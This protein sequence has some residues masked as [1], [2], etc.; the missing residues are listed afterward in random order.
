[1]KQNKIIVIFLLCLFSLSSLAQ[2]NIFSNLRLPFSKKEVM[3]INPHVLFF[4]DVTLTNGKNIVA[5]G[6][7]LSFQTNTY[8]ILHANGYL[9]SLFVR[10]NE[11]QMHSFDTM[12]L[13]YSCSFKVSKQQMKKEFAYL[14]VENIDG[15]CTLYINGQ[16][17]REYHNAFMRYND[18]IKPFLK[19]GKNKLRLVF[20]PKDSVRMNQRSPQYLYGWD[21]HPKTLAPSIS[22]IYLSFEDN[23]PILDYKSIQTKSIKKD[24]AEVLLSLKFRKPLTKKHILSLESDDYSI[25]FILKPNESGEYCFPFT[26]ENPKLWWPNGSGE[27]YLYKSK[28]LIDDVWDSDIRYG[29]RTIELVRKK[30]TLHNPNLRNKKTIGESFYFNVNGQPV[31]CK[32]ANFITGPTT[33]T[34]DI[35]LAQE[36]NMN[37]LRVWGGANYGD[38]EFYNLCDEYGIMVWQDFPF[39][40]ELYPADSSFLANVKE[41]A[42]QNI[43]RIS[44]H[45]SLALYCGNNEIWEGWNNWGWKQMVKDTTK[46]VEDYNKLFKEL[47][48]KLVSEYAPTIDYIHSSPLEYGWGHEESR[49]IG[50]CHY[51]GVWWGDST[52]E[53]YTRKV[54]RFMS[55]F[56]FQS[57]MNFSTAQKYCSSPY[58]KNND[59]F[60]I[61][62]K[63]DRGFELIDSRVK[64]WFGD[65]IKTDEDYITYTNLTAAEGLKLAIEAFRRAKP[66]C[67]GILFWQYNELY[68]CIGWG[69]IDYSSDVKPTYYTATLSYQP[70]IFSIDKY[71]NEDSVFVYACSDVDKEVELDYT[72]K[73]LDNNDSLHYKFIETTT[74]IPAN[75]SKLIASIAYKDIKD[76][77]KKTCYLW[78]EGTYEDAYINNYAFFSYP[79]DYISL[80]KYLDVI[81]FYYF[82]DDIR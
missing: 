62:Q 6:F 68:P 26:I 16:K 38:E 20:S 69:C 31:F 58:T 5:D 71:S 55:E 48:P 73:I 24:V 49:Q 14:N 22:A 50:D 35:I 53:T 75:E 78:A 7:D 17:V 2:N 72:I 56:G 44:G 80:Q 40:C 66:Y 52:F 15:N 8:E 76:F 42:T 33:K 41:E 21:W 57:A 37:M 36:A 60:A 59:A 46:A 23:K 9:D 29:I 34:S 61:H 74:N 47:L 67:M 3:E 82:G 54:P 45:P 10:E 19:K 77:D 28:I 32:G 51:W 64:E 30:D 12:T 65:V 63:H 18:N 27:Q 13:I 39:A 79:K 43:Q 70:V 4:Y 11:K 81:Y 1:M 25:D